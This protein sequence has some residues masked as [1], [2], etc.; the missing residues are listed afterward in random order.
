V[1]PFRPAKFDRDV[2]ALRIA[3][4][5]ETLAEGCDSAGE[6]GRGLGAEIS[7]HRHRRLLRS[8]AQRPKIRCRG[9]T[10]QS[11]ELAASPVE[12]GASFPPAA[13]APDP[14]GNYT[15]V[16]LGRNVDPQKDDQESH[17]Q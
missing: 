1:P 2:S 9:G 8:R 14:T 5:A 3:G 12:H 15:S 10:G 7:D 11:D 6:C 13:G 16:P 17:A 4:F